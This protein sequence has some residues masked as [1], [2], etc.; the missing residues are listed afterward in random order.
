MDGSTLRP[1]ASSNITTENNIEF[2]NVDIIGT[3]Q[4]HD[5]S[6]FENVRINGE[7]L[8]NPYEMS[9]VVDMN[10]SGNI[11]LPRGLYKSIKI[12]CS[13]PDVVTKLQLGN[14]D[15]G[16][17]ANDISSKLTKELKSFNGTEFT[18]YNL[19]FN[20]D[21]R[22]II[23]FNQCEAKLFFIIEL[24]PTKTGYPY[25]AMPTIN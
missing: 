4:L 21:A 15:T 17:A 6:P 8:V 3:F 18:S 7:N 22:K 2:Y 24:F 16:Y 14:M 10:K 19:K 25:L 1:Y 13:N 12:A 11:Q 20:T 5:L 23:Y 9:F